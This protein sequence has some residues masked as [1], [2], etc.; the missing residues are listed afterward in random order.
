MAPPLVPKRRQLFDKGPPREAP[1]RWKVG[2]V[3]GLAAGSKTICD[4]GAW[5]PAG[6]W[7]RAVSESPWSSWTRPSPS[8]A[9]LTRS[10][11]LGSRIARSVDVI[12]FPVQGKY[13][14]RHR[15]QLLPFRQE[16]FSKLLSFHVIPSI[17]P[18]AYDRHDFHFLLQTQI[19]RGRV[20]AKRNPEYQS[21]ALPSR[22]DFPA[23]LF[24]PDPGCGLHRRDFPPIAHQ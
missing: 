23:R 11:N 12:S 10:F 3:Q 16:Y 14:L 18:C 15:L 5:K 20:K 9:S 8:I 1:E 7:L 2:R 6:V 17:E 22:L 19:D 13:K 21:P 24:P 4:E